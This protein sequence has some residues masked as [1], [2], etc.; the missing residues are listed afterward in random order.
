MGLLDSSGEVLCGGKGDKAKRFIAPTLVA[1]LPENSPLL[2][3]EIFGPILPILEIDSI[4]DAVNYVNERPKP[5]VLYLF[6]ENPETQHFVL[7]QT[8][9]GG[10]VLNHCLLHNLSPDLP[11]G[12]VGESGMGAYHGKAGFDALSHRKSVLKKP[13]YLDNPTIYPNLT[14]RLS[15]LVEKLIKIWRKVR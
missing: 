2:K 4:Q 3:E 1:D 11:F 14:G 7:N 10:V 8:S 6:S 15:K 9:S 12:G 13:F 5:L